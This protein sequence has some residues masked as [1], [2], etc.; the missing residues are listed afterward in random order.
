MV[1]L[2]V[3]DSQIHRDVRIGSSAG[4]C[5]QVN[6]VSVIPREYPRL[7]AHY[8]VFFRKSTDTGQFEPA[9][10][11]GF[12][13]NENLF[14]V[15]GR[16]D[17]AYLP[18]QIQRQPFSL[19][20]RRGGGPGGEQATREVALDLSSPQVQTLE[21]ERVFLD[22]GRPSPYLTGITSMLSAL[23][24]GAREA[25]AFTG[26]LTELDLIE[27]V[28]LEIEFVDGSDAKLEGLYWIAEAALKELPAAQL[29]ELRDR[30]F[31]EWLY[32]QMASIAHLSGLIARKNRLLSGL[33]AAGSTEVRSANPG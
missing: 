27:P 26:R 33:P 19:M 1:D 23:V 6:I 30:R 18:L 24:T 29:M 20:P 9:A 2:V 25:Y 4:D 11:L 21:G 17:A 7:L 15:G 10:L 3:L 14:C 12:G 8:P 22:D 16:W 31:L 32:F 13:R 5:A 28:R